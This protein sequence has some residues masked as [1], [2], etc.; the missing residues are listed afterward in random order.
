MRGELLVES[1]SD[2]P[3]RLEAGSRLW[4]VSA[5]GKRVAVEVV[6]S[7][8]HAGGLL[9]SFRGLEDRDAVEPFG[10][11]WLEAERVTTP[12]APQG[13]YYYFELVG[14]SC[15]DHAA[16]E[17]G[18]VTDVV[19]DGGGLLLRVRGEA[20]ELLIPFVG[21]YLARV[22]IEG[23]RIE[24]TLPPGLAEACASSS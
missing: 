3:G 23:R 4:L 13:S 24:L 6:A 18:E 19:E 5:A 2:V 1:L 7:R 15:F 16:G 10:G 21:A 11:G 20:R 22:D 8:P 12:P 14:C 17:L 9:L